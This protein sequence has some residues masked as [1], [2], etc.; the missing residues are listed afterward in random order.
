VSDALARL[1]AV[2]SG[3]SLCCS[4]GGL[5]LLAAYMLGRLRADSRRGPAVRV[6]STERI[7][8]SEW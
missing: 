6:M 3:L 1:I 7:D 2:A 8:G 4:G 5:L